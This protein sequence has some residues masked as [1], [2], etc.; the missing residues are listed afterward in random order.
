MKILFTIY[1]GLGFGGAEVSAKYLAEGLKE[2]GHDVIFV[3]HGQYAGFKNY[4]LKDFENSPFLFSQQSYVERIIKGVIDDEKPDIV[5]CHDRLTSVGAVK[6]AHSKGIPVAVHFRDYWFACPY[7]TC[8][9]EDGFEYDIC[10]PKT[11]L[12]HFPMKRWLWDAYKLLYLRKSRKIVNSAELKLAL[13]NAVKMRL[14]AC[15]IKGSKIILSLRDFS[16]FSDKIKKNQIKKRFHLDRKVITYVGGL[17]KIKGILFIMPVI[18]EVIE[19]K[20]WCFLIAGDGPLLKE[21]QNLIDEKGLQERIKIAGKISFDEMP[22][23]YADS[24]IVVA[25]SLWEEPL[26]GV[27][28]EAGACAK[29][30][31][32]SRKGGNADVIDDG[33]TGILVPAVDKEAWKKALITLIED[34]KLRKKIGENARKNIIQKFN[35]KSYV[36][37][38]EE[39]YKR[40]TR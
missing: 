6:A 21:L 7:S 39:E 32:A 38:I 26:S 5:H 11:I 1:H 17:T 29:P 3:S 28:L 14:D 12:S 15:N 36:M 20:G 13:T 4:Y 23:V 35:I 10:T 9:A 16:R 2:R 40:L 24:D 27:L 30:V 34:E 8:V 22:F 19:E 37:K 33:K 25:P 31:I 18:A